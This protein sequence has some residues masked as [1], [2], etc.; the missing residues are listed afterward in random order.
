MSLEAIDGEP[1]PESFSS[2]AVTN[3]IEN[4]DQVALKATLP[5]RRL[6]LCTAFPNNCTGND[7][8][9]SDAEELSEYV[10]NYLKLP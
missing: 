6:W 7:Q 2:L 9:I 3:V 10:D 8:A 4:N 5:R 1:D